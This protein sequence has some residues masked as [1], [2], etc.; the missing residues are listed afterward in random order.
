MVPK[1]FLDDEAEP[2][3]NSSRTDECDEESNDE[4]VA[5]HGNK[6]DRAGRASASNAA[7]GTTNVD[8]GER[9]PSSRSEA[10]S[11]RT[12]EDK[13]ASAIAAGCLALERYIGELKD[14]LLKGEPPESAGV[15]GKALPLP[16]EEAAHVGTVLQGLYE[17]IEGIRRRFGRGYGCRPSD[18]SLTYMWAS[19]LLGKM[20]EVVETLKPDRLQKARGELPLDDSRFLLERLSVIEQMI[21]ELR[22]HYTTSRSGDASLGWVPHEDH[23]APDTK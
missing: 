23:S 12:F 19:V 3:G 5:A 17:E 2:E 14:T 4:P 22:D 7:E 9:Q 10:A 6:K 13:H 8:R 18:L 15:G 16:A 21:T 11:S 20:E 1:G